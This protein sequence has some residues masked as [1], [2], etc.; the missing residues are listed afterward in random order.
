MTNSG[1]ICFTNGKYKG[2]TIDEVASTDAGLLFLD[3]SVD[4]LA[5]NSRLRRSIVKYLNDP[6]IAKELEYLLDEGDSEGGNDI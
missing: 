6:V 1:S 2:K 5:K 3:A 4:N